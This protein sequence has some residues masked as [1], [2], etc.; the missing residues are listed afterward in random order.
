MENTRLLLC[1]AAWL[2]FAANPLST[3]W[4][5]LEDNP[6]P[7]IPP[8]AFEVFSKEAW[9][10]SN[11]AT[12][13]EMQ[14]FRDAKYG[15]FFHFGLS[16]YKNAELSWGICQVRV[17]PDKGACPYPSAEWTAWKDEFRIPDFDAKQ[18]VQNTQDAGMKYIVVIAK[19]HDCLSLWDTQASDHKITYPLSPYGKDIVGQLAAAT[20]AASLRFGVYYSQPDW[21]HPDAFSE[22]QANYLAYLEQQVRELM[23]HYGQIDIV[24]FDGLGKKPEEYGSVA[25]N[26]IIRELQPQALINNRNASHEDFDTPEQSVGTMEDKRPWKTCLPIGRSWSSRPDE[27]L[28]SLDECVRILVSTVTGGG[29]LLFNFGPVPDGRIEP[30]QVARLT[31]IGAW[32]T[33]NGIA[34]YNTRVGPCANGSW[35]GS[36]CRDRTIYVQLLKPPINNRIR[37]AALPHRITSARRLHGTAPVNF[38][39]TDTAVTLDLGT[40]PNQGT[41]T[42]PELTAAA[43]VA[44]YQIIGSA[45]GQFDDQYAFGT[46]QEVTAF[47]A[48]Q[49]DFSAHNSN[50]DIFVER[51]ADVEKWNE[52]YRGSYGLAHWEITLTRF[53]TGIQQPGI[54][55]RYVS[56]S[57][58]FGTRPS[59][60]Q[61]GKFA[62]YAT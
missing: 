38:T 22:R 36:T 26:K 28:K 21:I 40:N 16:T 17:A 19:H 60:L 45:A 23:T 18:L 9:D 58:D 12:P 32:M 1:A 48:V 30:R 20:R 61:L 2:A 33:R 3:M 47:S 62:L 46:A 43:P 59:S 5:V 31:E 42:I 10:K 53:F 56:V 39:Q 15:R 37:L 24:W 49:I 55:A 8:Q 7:R 27:K 6:R 29:N 57:G 54:P 34:L 25:L 13:E 4:S 51:S 41:V 35:G 52:V 44:P 11:F 14:W 50:A